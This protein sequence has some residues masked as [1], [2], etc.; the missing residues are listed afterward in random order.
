MN[1]E[2]NL[3]LREGIAKAM[4]I[5]HLEMQLSPIEVKRTCGPFSQDRG[6]VFMNHHFL[7][8]MVGNP[9]MVMLQTM[10][11]VLV[12]T[13]INT[14]VKEFCVGIPLFDGGNVRT[15]LFPSPLDHGK[16]DDLPLEARPKMYLVEAKETSSWAIWRCSMTSKAACKGTLELE[17]IPRLQEDKAL[18]VSLNL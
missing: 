13:G 4:Q 1:S 14:H 15:L 16:G 5:W 3:I 11:M 12:P 9:P 6:E 7:I 17:K 2:F 10:N 8:D 18:P